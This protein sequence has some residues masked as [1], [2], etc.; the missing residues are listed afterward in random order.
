MSMTGLAHLCS[1]LQNA[2]KAK[3]GITHVPMTRMNLNI[4]MCLQR[5]GFI[6]SVTRGSFAGPDKTYTPTTNQNVASRRLW[7]ELK[8][9]DNEPVL[10]KM[11]SISKPK[12]RLWRGVEDLKPLA[13]GE[14][15]KYVH[16]LK[17]GEAIILS[18][19]RGYFELR[20]AIEKKTGGQ[21][22]CRVS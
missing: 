20:E 2:T 8:Y 13:K 1:H 10:S 3:L 4:L 16:G 22:L 11:S 18:T 14:W 9:Y 21:L 17:P 7:V 6:S 15:W 19:D 12:Q 5:E